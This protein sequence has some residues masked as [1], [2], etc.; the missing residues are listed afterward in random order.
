MIDK[1]K[2]IWPVS[3]DTLSV[4]KEP[5]L[6]FFPVFKNSVCC[7]CYICLQ[8]AWVPSVPLWVPSPVS[9]GRLHCVYKEYFD[10]QKG[11]G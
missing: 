7:M 6:F 4:W 5:Y 9:W 2:E 11:R 10:S 1:A 8:Q 3:I